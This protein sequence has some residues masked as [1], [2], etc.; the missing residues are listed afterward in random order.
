VTKSSLLALSISVIALFPSGSYAAEAKAGA[1]VYAAKC[2][3]CHAADGAGN[4]AV[5]KVMNV[6]MEP[7]GSADIQAKSDADLKSVVTMGT[8]KM[9]PVTGVT[10][11]DLAARGSSG[12]FDRQAENRTNRCQADE[13]ASR[14]VCEAPAG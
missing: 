9:K 10:G 4:P 3:T 6:T 12:Y 11:A 13:P 7:L 5:A 14:R 1:A 8:G 2:R